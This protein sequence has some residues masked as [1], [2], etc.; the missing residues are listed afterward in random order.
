MVTIKPHLWFDKEAMEAA[1]FYTGLFDHSAVLDTTTLH[2]APSGTNEIVSIVLAGQAFDLLSA[3]PYVRFNPAVSFL[4][5]LH[6]AGEVDA[7]W[8]KLAPGGAALME[9]GTYPFS[10]RYGWLQDKYGLSWQVMHMGDRPV[11][12]FIT[13]TL[14]FVGDVCG[15]A[16][17]AITT[18]ASVFKN[19]RIG[20]IDRY[21]AGEEPDQPGTI[22]HAAFRLENLNFAAMDSAQ[23][24]DFRFNEAI[25]FI[26]SCETQD[27]IDY[28]WDKLSADPGAEACGW[29]KDQ[30][31]LSW[32]IVPAE[33]DAMLR[34]QN[35]EK[36][37]RL[38]SAVLAMKKLDI[39]ALRRALDG[40]ALT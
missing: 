23:A 30:Y 28:F 24:H 27:E 5:A 12:Q 4:V 31:G 38:T 37:A 35:S 15:K 22:R 11:E 14:M 34:E 17:E 25:S 3:G 20:A 18:Y 26:V 21:G 32:Q 40:Q 9:L 8:A 2:D 33:L 7:L 16:E 36:V 19:S 1:Q 13:P 10:A 39:A 6:S 29:L